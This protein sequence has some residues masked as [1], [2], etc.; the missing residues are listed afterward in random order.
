MAKPLVSI[1][2][3][4]YNTRFFPAALDSAMA[5][6]Y[7]EL[8]VIVCD[9]SADDGI[10]KYVERARERAP[11]PIH[12]EKNPTRLIRGNRNKCYA[13]SRGEYIK[14]LNDD[15]LL[16]PT[17]IE[18]M[19]AVIDDRPD[20]SLVTS[21]RELIDE[22]GNAQPGIS[23]TLRPVD[24]DA[25]IA[26]RSLCRAVLDSA[27]NFIGEPTSVLFRRRD[28]APLLPDI[29]RFHGQPVTYFSDVAM[30][31]TLLQAGDAAYLVDTLS[32]FRRHTGQAQLRDGHADIAI[33]NYRLL[34]NLS[35]DAGLIDGRENARFQARELWRP[36]GATIAWRPL[37]AP[38]TSGWRSRDLCFREAGDAAVAACYE[39]ETAAPEQ[40]SDERY[41]ALNPDVRPVVDRG[42]TSA[43]EHSLFHGRVE[44]RCGIPPD[45]EDI[46]Q[47]TRDCM[48]P[49][50]EYRIEPGG[51]VCPCPHHPAVD[52]VF[53]VTWGGHPGMVDL[54]RRLL[55]GELDAWC[56]ACPAMPITSAQQLT[57]R[58]RATGDGLRGGRH[59]GRRTAAHSRLPPRTGGRKL[60]LVGHAAN[61]TGGEML[62]LALLRHLVLREDFEVA[63]ILLGGGEL[64]AEYRQFGDVYCRGIDFESDE[65]LA[66]LAHALRA[67]GFWR[68]LCNTVVTGPVVPLLKAHG[69][70]V[71]SLIHELP[72]S[73]LN[74]LG[75]DKAEAVTAAAD[76]IV[77]AADHVRR[78]FC[79]AF[80]VAP[81]RT[82]VRP[83][84]LL[85][86]P[87]LPAPDAGI[88]RQFRR[89]W[90][91]AEGDFVVLGVGSGDLRKGPDL[92]FQVALQAIRS[93]AASLR[94]VWVGRIDAMTRTW[95]D[96]D[97]RNTQL[98]E[99]VTFVEP[100]QDLSSFYFGAD[101][102]LLTSREDP[103]PNVVLDCM[104]LGLPVIAFAEAG[105]APE[106]LGDDAGM[107]VPYLDTGAMAAAVGRIA[108]N[109]ELRAAIASAAR[110]RVL[111]RCSMAAYSAALLEC[112]PVELP[113]ISVVIPNYNYRQFLG[114]RLDSILSQTLPIKEIIFLDDA[115]TD[116]SVDLFRSLTAHSPI[117]V[118][119]IENGTNSGSVFSQWIK[120]A[121]EAAGDL[122][123]IAEADDYCEPTLLENLAHAF[124]DRQVVLAYAQSVFVDSDGERIADGLT[125]TAGLEQDKWGSSHFNRGTLE[126]TEALVVRNTIV[127][128]S[129]ALMRRDAFLTVVDED[130]GRAVR[131]FAVA[132]DW[133]SYIRMLESGDIYF[134]CHPLNY[135]RRHTR[136][137]TA[138]KRARLFE[139]VLRV[140][141]Y[142]LDRH[143]IAP[144]VLSQV[145]AEQAFYFRHSHDGDSGS[146]DYRESDI[147]RRIFG[148]GSGSREQTR[149]IQPA[150]A[151]DETPAPAIA[152][153]ARPSASR[154]GA[155][156]PKDELREYRR[157][158][159]LLQR[160]RHEDA[161]AILKSLAERGSVQWEIYN[162]LGVLAQQSGRLD[163]AKAYLKYGASLEFNSTNCLR[164]LLPIYIQESE[165]GYAL[166]V[167]AAILKQEP[168]NE[169]IGDVVVELLKTTRYQADSLDWLS[170]SRTTEMETIKAENR[171]LQT[172][173][174]E[175][176]SQVAGLTATQE[177][178]NKL[179]RR[180]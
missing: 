170:P 28:L 31:F 35:Q 65:E 39:G 124:L 36:R 9:D 164:N 62:L 166:G 34:C 44:G 30:W 72:T 66:A 163:E 75:R 60:V 95:L 37:L 99:R 137:V 89:R 121:R 168:D 148:A 145:E 104:A 129:A 3:P 18:R 41:L 126:I 73:I 101:A 179:L 94:F 156:S 59:T 147:Y 125:H 8:E 58:I 175:L 115:S 61:R 93:C 159:G 128:V 140:Q 87:L 12:Y 172:K 173:A 112:L 46:K 114:Q 108:A 57:E 152:A 7:P 21:H 113:S 177:R 127:N 56:T 110:E 167:A 83:Q 136:S 107:V 71:A 165:L 11:F 92:F 158:G 103:F 80:Q 134:H 53:A 24:Q 13:L 100:Q 130:D 77:F 160:G 64:E 19:V 82:L 180:R 122:L 4:A 49:W 146:A 106:I 135:Q 33:E 178:T 97:L 123:W 42:E 157:A 131:E 15:D 174:R 118:R 171:R 155:L 132:G 109:P 102:F 32:A 27:V 150:E 70:A 161:Y 69:M 144:E 154:A 52:N 88:R 1:L 105:G 38:P 117:P 119:I 176:E 84:G 74:L 116:D 50:Q 14:F 79:A 17:C 48:A 153:A 91:F 151:P 43:L 2:I 67:N 22:D 29:L 98:A 63:T 26:G 6:T 16:V 96:H 51:N 23:A 47:P 25:V 76:R 68:A 139:E 90:R 141:K 55:T 120:G 85:F 133:L 54:R 143:A 149:P 45:Q 138:D 111:A 20:I 10:G 40:F 81:E 78:E 162:D 5:Q 86:D 169:A 142:V